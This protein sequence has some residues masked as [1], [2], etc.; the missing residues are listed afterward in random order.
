[1]LFIKVCCYLSTLCKKKKKL[2]K[3]KYNC[4]WLSVSSLLSHVYNIRKHSYASVHCQLIKLDYLRPRVIVTEFP[5]SLSS[6]LEKTIENNIYIHYIDGFYFLFFL[7][8]Y[9]VF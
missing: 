1:M 7:R 5:Q 3:I 9:P 6:R 8:H 4:S 2:L